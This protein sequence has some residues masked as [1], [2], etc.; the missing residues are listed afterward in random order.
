MDDAERLFRAEDEVDIAG[1]RPPED[2]H[3]R[4][5]SLRGR[6][7]RDRARRG[8]ALLV[9][10]PREPMLRRVLGTLEWIVWGLQEVLAPQTCRVCGRRVPGWIQVCDGC[11]ASLPWISNPCPICARPLADDEDSDLPCGRCADRRLRFDRS[12]APVRYDGAARD[13]ILAYKVGR[14]RSLARVLVRFF[15]ASPLDEIAP[16]DAVTSVP[17]DWLRRLVRG[18]EPPELIARL[19]AREVGAPYERLLAKPAHRPRQVG[20]GREARLRNPRGAFRLRRR[21][22]IQGKRILLVDDIL[23]T[24]ATA[25]ECAGVLRDGGASGVIVAALARD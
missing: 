4:P 10:R 12:F 17:S 3:R 6:R 18:F 25:D 7:G 15:E 13:L 11:F 2:V 22:R 1:H 16:P 20:L 14:E 8:S 19:L 21:A 5:D 24:G 23:T 9:V